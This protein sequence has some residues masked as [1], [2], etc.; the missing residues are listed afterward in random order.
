[1][2]WTCH[3]SSLG[4]I[5]RSTM[6]QARLDIKQDPISKTT[7]AKRAVKKKKKKKRKRQAHT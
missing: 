1:M 2:V 6:V 4:S 3:P 5:N 7:K